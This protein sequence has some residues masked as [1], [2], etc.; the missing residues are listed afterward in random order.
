MTPDRTRGWPRRL[1]LVLGTGFGA[2]FVPRAPGTAGS[3]VGLGLGLGLAAAALDT[4]AVA[5]ITAAV[6]V[7]GVPI[8]AG[9]AR[10][11]GEPDPPAVVWDEIAGMLVTL[12]AVPP[13]WYWWMAAFALFRAFDVLKPWPIGWLERRVRGGAGIMLDDLVAGA[14]AGAAV[15]ALARLAGGGS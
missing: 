8:C 5:A 6:C 10:A 4:A 13:G 7:A 14:F 11:L 15:Q 9:A 2:G 12:L 1:V 3:V